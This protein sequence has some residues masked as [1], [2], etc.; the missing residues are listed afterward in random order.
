[1]DIERPLVKLIFSITTSRAGRAV[2]LICALLVALAPASGSLAATCTADPDR[3]RLEEE[4]ERL[5]EIQARVEQPILDLPGVVGLGIGR[6]GDRLVFTILVDG[7]ARAADLPGDLEG[8]P[9]RVQPR[10][11]V[12]L[13]DGPPACGDTFPCHVDQLPLPVEM[14]NSGGWVSQ[15]G[16]GACSL[17]FKACDLATGE[18]VFVT[19]SHCNQ[20]ASTCGL[21]T[22]GLATSGWMHPGRMDVTANAGTCFSSGTCE[23]I[24]TITGHAA[25]A[26]GS[27][28]NFTD[29]TKVASSSQQ[30]S[31]AFRDVGFPMGFPGNPLPGDPVRKS[32]RTTGDTGGLVE[33]VNV[34]LEVPAVGGFCCGTLT[35][36]DQV[37]WQSLTGATKGGDSGS[38]LLSLE[39]EF[40]VVGLNWG[41]DGTFT[42]A[43]HIDR[44]LSA[45]DLSLA[46]LD[47]LEDCL[48]SAAV[49]VGTELA[50]SGR[51]EDGAE[52]LDLGRR[53]RDEVL[54][55]S[56]VGRQL[57]QMYHQFS[58]EAVRLARRSPRLLAHTARLLVRYAPNLRALVVDGRTRV[59][60]GDLQQ[61]RGLLDRYARD[62]SDAMRQAIRQVQV[63]MLDPEVQRAIGVEVI[64]RPQR[65]P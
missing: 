64:G 24:G 55:G 15:T 7:S 61:V 17:G 35:M 28:S 52:L 25:P 9:V 29:A 19:N 31:I 22:P 37:E 49:E 58:G 46:F 54:A 16:A 4:L 6:S 13:L 20:S 39:D 3:C 26:C 53:F 62:S 34:T 10:D 56:R 60:P 21:P 40:R 27:G 12:R 45:L 32:G 43:N 1:M 47:C 18:V 30:T 65:S 48:F 2:V 23:A 44:V 42:Y 59:T 11:P 8:V 41:S 33:T 38:A 5:R 51:V 57:S 63:A 36:K 50:G 14:G